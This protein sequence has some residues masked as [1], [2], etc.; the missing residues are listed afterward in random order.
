MGNFVSAI[1]QASSCSS[2]GMRW[3]PFPGDEIC[4]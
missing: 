1:R 2:R 3:L 4:Y